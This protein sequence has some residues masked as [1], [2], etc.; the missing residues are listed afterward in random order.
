MDR[1]AFFKS[2]DELTGND[3]V[4]GSPIPS[5]AGSPQ[6]GETPEAGSGN[7]SASVSRRGSVQ[8]GGISLDAF[9]RAMGSNARKNRSRTELDLDE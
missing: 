7:N 9:K 8:G 6:P 2:S 1:M 3:S 5:R 4:V